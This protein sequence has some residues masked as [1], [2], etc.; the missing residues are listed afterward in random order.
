[1]TPEEIKLRLDKVGKVQGLIKLLIDKGNIYNKWVEDE[2]ASIK[3]DIARLQSHE[4]L[5]AVVKYNNTVEENPFQHSPEP[6]KRLSIKDMER[7]MKKPTYLGTVGLGE[8][9]NKILE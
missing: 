5:N 8:D 3:E 7:M 2:L 9:G 6:V 1:M 4:V